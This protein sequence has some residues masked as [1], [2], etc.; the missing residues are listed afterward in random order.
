MYTVLSKY[1]FL[2]KSLLR[3]EGQHTRQRTWFILLRQLKLKTGRT[4]KKKKFAINNI[5]TYSFV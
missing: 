4:E 2:P 3:F 1:R 5:Q